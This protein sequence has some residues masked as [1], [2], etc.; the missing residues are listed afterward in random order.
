M[1][2]FRPLR[3]DMERLFGREQVTL[4]RP[5]LN[6]IHE[7]RGFSRYHFAE[8]RRLMEQ[9]V[10]ERRHEEL[11]GAF[12]GVCDA[13]PGD[14]EQARFEAA[15][16]ITACVHSMHSL[17]DIIGQTLYLALG[18]NLDPALAIEQ[19]R[20]ISLWYVSRRLPAGRV[21]DLVATLMRGP[22]FIYLAAMNN[23]SKHRSVVP[24]VFSVDFTN[25]EAQTHGLRFK[26]FR[27]AEVDYPTRWVRTTLINEYQR[28]EQLLGEI[29]N[30]LNAELAG[31]V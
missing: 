27:Y 9:A 17:A 10:G 28:Q 5:C 25:E 1:W 6:A 29:G 19:E 31:R 2:D 21:A 12:L 3:G 7:W 24:V 20:R 15:A 26:P 8:A 14:F 18:M 30:A 16:H 22:D 13:E 11:V 23:H 4:I